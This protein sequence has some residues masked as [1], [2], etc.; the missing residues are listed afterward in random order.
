MIRSAVG[1]AVVVIC[2]ST[3]YPIDTVSSYPSLAF[4]AEIA[5]G[6][7]PWVVAL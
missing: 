4:H 1:R 7:F 6:Q 5:A 2:T 3:Y